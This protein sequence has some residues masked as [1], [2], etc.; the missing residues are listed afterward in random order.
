MKRIWQDPEYRARHYASTW[1]RADYR[2]AV[3]AATTARW[4]DPEFARVI[5]EKISAGHRRAREAR[6][7]RQAAME[8]Q[9]AE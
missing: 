8:A 1:A 9:A 5:G 6:L 4:A 2:E 3:T 7:A